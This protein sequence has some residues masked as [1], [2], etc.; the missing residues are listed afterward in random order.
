MRT[1]G[2]MAGLELRRKDGSPATAEALRVIKAMLRRGFILLPEG[3]HSNV[4]SFTPP[5]TITEAHLRSAVRTLGE[6]LAAL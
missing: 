2:L 3:E 6:G 5:L 4:I 1:L